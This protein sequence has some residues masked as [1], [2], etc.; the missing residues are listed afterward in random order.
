MCSCVTISLWTFVAILSMSH[1]FLSR[2]SYTI[3]IAGLSPL[4]RPTSAAADSCLNA[5]ASSETFYCTDCGTGTWMTV[6]NCSYI[7][8]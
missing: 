8:K 2:R 5:K 1:S 6:M 3:S 4:T 7:I